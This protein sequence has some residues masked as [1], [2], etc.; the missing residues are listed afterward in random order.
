MRTNVYLATGSFAQGWKAV[1]KR[2]DIELEMS[3]DD[4][5]ERYSCNCAFPERPNTVHRCDECGKQGL[6]AGEFQSAL[7]TRDTAAV[8]VCAHIEDMSASLEMGR[9]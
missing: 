2:A 4:N 8:C 6:C 7:T 1:C 9:H 3:P 5:D